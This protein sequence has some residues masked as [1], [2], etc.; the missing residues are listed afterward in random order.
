MSRQ[1]ELESSRR[2]RRAGSASPTNLLVAALLSVL[3]LAGADG[4][5][6]AA[7]EPL[8]AGARR[9]GSMTLAQREFVA[10]LSGFVEGRLRFP[11]I[12]LWSKPGGFPAGAHKVAEVRSGS[13]VRVVTVQ[14][15]NAMQWALVSSFG[16]NEHPNGW[17]PEVLLRAQ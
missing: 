10:Q 15:V 4:R 14:R 9:A 5:A 12:I 2:A 11:T 13:L 3:L 16:V 17:V 8:G 6:A 7:M 1:G